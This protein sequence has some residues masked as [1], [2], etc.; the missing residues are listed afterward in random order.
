MKRTGY[1]IY[2]EDTKKRTRQNP[3]PSAYP[4]LPKKQFDIIYADPPWDYNGK[5]QFDKSSMPAENVGYRRNIFISSACF[6]YL[7][8]TLDQLMEI[9]VQEITKDDALLFMWTSSPHL[10]QA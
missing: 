2:N 4:E 8:L 3:L 7:T 1:S 10:V 5:L 6:K 9:P